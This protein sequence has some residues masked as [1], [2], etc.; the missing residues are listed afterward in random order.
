MIGPEKVMEDV[1]IGLFHD[2]EEH[3]RAAQEIIFRR[4]WSPVQSL[5]W[6]LSH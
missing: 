4:G 2:P 1:E 5:I 6:G 3:L